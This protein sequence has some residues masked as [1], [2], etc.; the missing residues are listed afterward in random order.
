[1]PASPIFRQLSTWHAGLP[2]GR[3]LDA[4]T[5]AHSLHWV[6]GLDTTAWTAV[7]ASASMAQ[8][9]RAAVQ[10]RM[11]AQD[12]IIVGDWTDAGLLAGETFDTVLADYLLGAVEGFAPYFQPCLFARL[13]PL[14]GRRLYV[15][16]LQPYV[17][18]TPDDPAGRLVVEMGRVRDACLLL[19]GERPYREYPLDWVLRSLREAG[20]RVLAS[21]RFPIRYGRRYID[22][23]IDMCEARLRR[24]AD[25]SLAQAMRAHLAALRTRAYALHDA[26]GGLAHGF[27]YAVAAEPF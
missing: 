8:Q 9:V 17:P 21:E 20:L 7:T 24:F 13:R 22:A 23:Q 5:G 14:V 15:V 10:P 3:M 26:L 11:R 2:W 6:S 19:A 16:G 12:R 27:D 1:M 4:G 18:Y 25:P